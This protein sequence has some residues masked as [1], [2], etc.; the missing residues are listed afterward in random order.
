MYI[1][2]KYVSPYQH[3]TLV[4]MLSGAKPRQ[5][6]GSILSADGLMHAYFSGSA[7]AM[8]SHIGGLL[9]KIK[10]LNKETL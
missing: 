5:D 10:Y 4:C 2:V 3:G 9:L 1:H 8:R 7:V 6:A